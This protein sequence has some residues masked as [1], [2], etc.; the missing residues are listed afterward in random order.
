MTVTIKITDLGGYFW[1]FKF[2]KKD[3]YNTKLKKLENA[4]NNNN[5]KNKCLENNKLIVLMNGINYYYINFIY[6]KNDKISFSE[7]S[8]L[9]NDLINNNQ[10]NIIFMDMPINI[11]DLT[12]SFLI[13]R[14]IYFDNL[15]KDY[16]IAY[17][18]INI[19]FNF[20]QYISSDCTNYKEIVFSAVKIMGCSLKYAS[21]E[22]QDDKDIVLEAVKNSGCS[23]EYASHELQ[24][25]T[26]ILLEAVKNDG[27]SLRYASINLQGIKDIVL[28]AVKNNGNSLEY[29]SHELLNSLKL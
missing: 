1:T 11:N 5:T 12:K 13:F 14:N 16:Y 23:L 25:D 4:L 10:L 26:D 20:L 21:H 18:L 22:L 3:G 6:L 19:N 17:F 2:N 29:A 7:Y 9:S 8:I 24:D 27:L 28:E 15:I